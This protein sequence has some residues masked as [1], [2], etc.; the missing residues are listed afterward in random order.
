M[1]ASQARSHA[2]VAERM[3]GMFQSGPTLVHAAGRL[4]GGLQQLQ[5]HVLTQHG[6]KARPQTPRRFEFRIVEITHAEAESDC[7]D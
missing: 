4:Q 5:F 7:E 6:A 2:A 1:F 3:R